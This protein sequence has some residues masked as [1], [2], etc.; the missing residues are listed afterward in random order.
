VIGLGWPVAGFA[1]QSQGGNGQGENGGGNYGPLGPTCSAG[2]SV[3]YHRQS[4]WVTGHKF[5]SSKPIT[6]TLDNRH[7]TLGSTR[8]DQK[9]RFRRT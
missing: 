3:T 7:V 4:V 1:G 9:A 6:L 5:R 8:S 2:S